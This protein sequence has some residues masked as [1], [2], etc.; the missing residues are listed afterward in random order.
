[1]KP[2][3][4]MA[5]IQCL[6]AIASLMV[7]WVHAKEQLPWLGETFPSNLGAHGVDLFFALS[8]FI[9]VVSTWG[10]NISPFDFMKR[11]LA[12]IAPLYWLS[13]AFLLIMAYAAPNL[14]KSTVISWP[15]VV[16]S[17]LFYPVESPSLHGHFMPLVVPGWTLN[18]EM[19]F[20]GLFALSLLIGQRSRHYA[21]AIALIVIVCYGLVFKPP[22]AV[23]FYTDAIILIFGAGALLGHLYCTDFFRQRPVIGWGIIACAT[24]FLL[25]TQKIDLYHRA[26]GAGIPALVVLF[27]AC[28]LSGEK[29]SW[30]KFLVSLGDA[31]YSIYLSHV[32]VLAAARP[33]LAFTTKGE[34]NL[35]EA[36]VLMTCELALCSG[37]G[38]LVYKVVESPLNNWISNRV[39][40]KTSI[41]ARLHH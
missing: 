33:L 5:N 6:R 39:I 21:V 13:T 4:Q 11:R 20:Y 29:R 27:G 30:P 17:F 26:I 37:I 24:V 25:A 23:G 2:A 36:A 16:G 40:S 12:R 10:K 18:Y 41:T 22:G 28:F 8:G 3:L 1:M 9:M 7:V 38:L 32:F 34:H 19:A 31:S 15:H 14:L 35:A